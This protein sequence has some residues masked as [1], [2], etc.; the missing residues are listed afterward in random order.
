MLKK[1]MSFFLLLTVIAFCG[2]TEL[3]DALSAKFPVIMLGKV[4]E[5]N[6]NYFQATIDWRM[7]GVHASEIVTVAKDDWG[8]YV[9]VG[10]RVIIGV[11]RSL[12][13][14]MDETYLP[15]MTLTRFDIFEGQSAYRV[16]HETTDYALVGEIHSRITRAEMAVLIP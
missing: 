6:G 7:K 10:D 1:V 14:P 5:V 9:K 2:N 13:R 3:A 11:N 15:G 8:P 12:E 16:L 4:T